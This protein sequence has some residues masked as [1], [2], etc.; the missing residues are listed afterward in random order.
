MAMSQH[1]MT[2][3]RSAAIL[4]LGADQ[5]RVVA[6]LVEPVEGIYR[7]IDWTILP[8]APLHDPHHKLADR[9]VQASQQLGKRVG[10]PLWRRDGRGPYLHDPEP[11]LGLALDQVV[12]VAD[13]LPPLRVWVAGVSVGESLAAAQEAL[14]GAF[15]QPVALYR[16]T[17]HE[18]D[19]RLAL[20]LADSAADVVVVTGGYDRSERAAQDPVLLLCERI[21]RA[22]R[23]LHPERRPLLC[24]AGNRYAASAALEIWREIPEVEA[25][26][27]L[28]VA[29]RAD[30]ILSSSLAITLSQLY[31]KR[32]QSHP[33]I[34]QINR[35]IS[36]PAV[37]RSLH[38]SFAQAVR[39]W[40]EVNNL[41]D[42]HALYC[43]PQQW[44]HVWASAGGVGVRV[45]FANPG[46]RLPSLAQWPPLQLVS[47]PWPEELWPR[48]NPHWWDPRSLLPVVA[49]VGQILPDAA[50]QVMARDLFK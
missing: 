22:V 30:Q 7:L 43:G 35:W 45:R 16:M 32:S 10:R 24:F 21:G 49:N 42:L 14:T 20:D 44:M 47:G 33:S 8:T 19:F 9:L 26:A 41:P 29:P 5:E 37:L 34:Q 40:R 1:T 3:Y 15:C 28:N 18:D 2:G 23:Q 17:A 50:L 6:A 39:M 48:H 11:A 27:V 46:N 12:A 25:E 31:W 36:S 4:A 13:P 38:W